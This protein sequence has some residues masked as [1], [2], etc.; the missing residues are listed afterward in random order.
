MYVHTTIIHKYF[1]FYS[2]HNYEWEKKKK[3]KNFSVGFKVKV[4][5]Y[6][7]LSIEFIFPTYE[8]IYIYIHILTL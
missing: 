5:F 3:K 4:T 7:T 8:K 2:S 1:Y 6:P